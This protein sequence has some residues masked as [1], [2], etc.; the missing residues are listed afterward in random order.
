MEEE[1]SVGVSWENA[2]LSFGQLRNS[3]NLEGTRE[4]WCPSLFS[5]HESLLDEQICRN[6]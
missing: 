5:F 3:D 1:V 4:E 6:R 2:I